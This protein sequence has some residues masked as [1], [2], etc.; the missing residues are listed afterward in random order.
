M[1]LHRIVNNS[2]NLGKIDYSINDQ[3]DVNI[4]DENDSMRPFYLRAVGR[5]IWFVCWVGWI[6]A[7]I[8]SY[9]RYILYSFIFNKYKTRQLIPIDVLIFVSASIQHLTNLGRMIFYTIMISEG[10]KSDH[11]DWKV[12]EIGFLLCSFLRFSLFFELYYSC[13][14]SLGISI[15]HILY[16]K[17][18]DFVKYKVGEWNLLVLILIGGILLT[19]LLTLMTFMNDYEKLLTENCHVP[20]NHNILLA[21]DEYKIAGGYPS[22]YIHFIYPR[23]IKRT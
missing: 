14:G 16:I 15:Y 5:Y 8:G 13:V 4:I 22:P 23:V 19:A 17:H 20:A 11:W 10:L 21:L 7:V 12:D 9:F 2:I 18:D 3:I 6:L 1:I